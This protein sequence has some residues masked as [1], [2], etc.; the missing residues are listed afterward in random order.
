MPMKLFTPNQIKYGL[1]LSLVIVVC[2]AIMEL[3]GQN[4][5][6]DKSPVTMVFMFI[7][8]I[9]LYYLGINTRK[10]AQ[11]N[12]LTFKQGVKEGFKIALVYGLISPFV[13]ALYYLLIN[14]GIVN[15][16]R[17]SYAMTNAST[18]AVIGVD[19]LIQLV[20]ALIIGTIFS[21]IISFFVK[22][23]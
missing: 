18:A 13:F 5:S 14:P 3:T 9:V 8:P 21:A 20:T 16:V 2:L 12:K 1:L 10:Q 11:G 22:T 6:F 23:K 19:M 7:A 4:E 15:Y 17:E